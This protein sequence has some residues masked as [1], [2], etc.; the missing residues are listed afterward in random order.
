MGRISKAVKEEFEQKYFVDGKL[1]KAKYRLDKI[2]KGEWTCPLMWKLP[3]L[4]AKA[5]ERE[6]YRVDISELFK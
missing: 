1:D 3:L 6:A 5:E 2:A 4:I